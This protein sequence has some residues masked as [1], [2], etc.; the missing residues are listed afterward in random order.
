MDTIRPRSIYL[1][2][3]VTYY[4]KKVKPFGQAVHYISQAVQTDVV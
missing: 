1:M 3:M 4:L 2:Y